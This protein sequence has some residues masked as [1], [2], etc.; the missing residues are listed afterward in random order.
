M[1]AHTTGF[2]ENLIELGR[3]LRGVITYNNTAGGYHWKYVEEV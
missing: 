1:K 3:E 2:K